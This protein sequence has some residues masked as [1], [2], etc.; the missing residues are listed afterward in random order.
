MAVFGELLAELRQDKKMTQGEL[1]KILHVSAGTI[2]NYEKGVHLPDLEKLISIAELFQVTTDYLLGRC[3]SN[4]SPDVF[5]EV[6]AD[7]R[8]V[9]EIVSAIRQLSPE[10]KRALSLIIGDMEFNMV[11]R[12]YKGD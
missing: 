10:R 3:Q 8:T 2:S 5:Q 1:A 4:L 12:Q 9:G 6:L 7:K 11:V